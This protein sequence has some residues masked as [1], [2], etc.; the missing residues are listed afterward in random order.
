MIPNSLFAKAFV[1]S[2]GSSCRVPSIIPSLSYRQKTILGSG[3]AVAEQ[4]AGAQRRACSS[5]SLDVC[6]CIMFFVFI[7]SLIADGPPWLSRGVMPKGRHGVRASERLGFGGYSPRPCTS[8]RLSCRW[9]IASAGS[10][11]ARLAS[12]CLCAFRMASGQCHT[13]PQLA[14][15]LVSRSQPETVRSFSSGGIFVLVR[16]A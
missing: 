9:S 3:G 15:S 8:C 16:C 11:L 2:A 7:K 5:A 12:V 14:L 4:S 10:L 13:F 6:G 1:S